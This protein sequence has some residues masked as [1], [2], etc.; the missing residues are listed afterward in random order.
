MC[1]IILLLNELPAP[2]LRTIIRDVRA[3]MG[4]LLPPWTRI[5]LFKP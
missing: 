1:P 4:M 5:R 2:H 3:D